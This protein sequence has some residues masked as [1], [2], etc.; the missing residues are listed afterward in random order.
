LFK[1]RGALPFSIV[2]VAFPGAL[3]TLAFACFGRKA[4]D[5]ARAELGEKPDNRTAR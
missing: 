1:D 3:A 4:V 5:R 2:L